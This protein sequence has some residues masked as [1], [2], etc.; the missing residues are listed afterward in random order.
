M[1]KFRGT[2]TV[3][4]TPFT[5]DG[6]R[7]DVTA[8]RRL[9]EFQIGEGIHG[10]IPL[11]STGEFLSVTR[12]E[13]QQVIETVIDQAKGRPPV[14]I[15]TGAERTRDVVELS[16]EAERVRADGLLYIPPIF[17]AHTE[18]HISLHY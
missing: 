17:R 13:R 4:I 1:T 7:V 14:L 6:K 2:Y 11:G 9:V 10:L 16:P 15:G 8:L 18:V 5:A 12:E 3:L